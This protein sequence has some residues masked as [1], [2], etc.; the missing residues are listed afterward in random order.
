MAELVPIMPTA[1]DDAIK[2]DTAACVFR[3]YVA[4]EAP[5]SV[6][7]LRNLKTICKTFYP[8]DCQID[9]VDVLLSPERAWA[10]GVIV[11]PTVMRI[12]P[13]SVV[14]IMGNL[15]DTEQV[16]NALNLTVEN[17]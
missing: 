14:R 2:R 16:L 17:N 8:D 1:P 5:N 15:S 12:A 11:T 10:D 13:G 4:G 6:L 9:V 3:L 7:A